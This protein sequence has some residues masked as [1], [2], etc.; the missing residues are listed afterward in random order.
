MPNWCSN[1]LVL[2]HKDPAKVKQAAEA[3]N[4]G[5]LL[6]TLFPEPDY[7]TTAVAKAFPEIDAGFAKSDEEK[8]KIL[9][10]EPEI[11]DD[12]W[13]DWRVT[14]WGTKWDVGGDGYEA[15]ISDDGFSVIMSFDSAWSPPTNAYE[16]INEEG[17]GVD[18]YYYEPGMGFCGVWSDGYDDYYDISGMDSVEVEDLLPATLNENFAISENMAQWEAE[19]AEDE[20]EL[21]EWYKDGVDA[22][23]LEPHNGNS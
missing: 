4:E 15:E 13:W 23:G 3:F 10:N 5:H 21:T 6:A 11:R 1:V 12:A 2:S 7:K 18:A 19:N 22:K 14:N 20:E 17:W 8:A 9:A 16:K